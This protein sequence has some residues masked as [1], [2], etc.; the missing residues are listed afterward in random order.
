[1]QRPLLVILLLVMSLTVSA[2][3]PGWHGV[4]HIGIAVPDIDEATEFLVEVIGCEHLISA[5]PFGAPEGDWMTRQFGVHP[6]ARVEDMRM[7][8]CGFGSNV[9][10]FEW[11]APDQRKISPRLSDYGGLHIA[12]YVDDLQAA[13]VYLR[14]KGVEVLN[15]PLSSTEGDMAGDSIIYVKAPWGGFL[16]LVSSPNG[17]GYEKNT[18][19]RLWHPARPGE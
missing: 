11:S 9:E 18:D 14:E 16:E 7:L 19:R 13:I 5:G 1:M 6:R 8:R 17:K 4:D 3:L 10:L 2:R 12:L 15:E